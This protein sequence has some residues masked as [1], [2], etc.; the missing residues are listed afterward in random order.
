LLAISICSK[1]IQKRVLIWVVSLG[2]LEGFHEI[3]CVGGTF[4]IGCVE[5]LRNNLFYNVESD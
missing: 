3:G 4:F 1:F 5:A 2:L